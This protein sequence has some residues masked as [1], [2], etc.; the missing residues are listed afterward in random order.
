MIRLAGGV[1]HK[2]WIALSSLSVAALI[3]GSLQSL[4]EPAECQNFIILELPTLSSLASSYKKVVGRAG[5][6]HGCFVF[7]GKL[8]KTGLRFEVSTEWRPLLS[9]SQHCLI[10]KCD[11]ASWF[12]VNFNFAT[13][14]QQLAGCDPW[15]QL[16]TISSC[17]QGFPGWLP[18]TFCGGSR[19]TS[20]PLLPRGCIVLFLGLTLLKESNNLTASSVASACTLSHHCVLTAW[21]EYSLSLSK[22]QTFVLF[23]SFASI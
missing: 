19:R 16:H 2:G 12:L 3:W 1:P 5:E 15:L 7:S 21:R 13:P 6:Q 17:Q 14:V 23:Q 8:T 4:W 20:L 10:S 18:L 22:K 9:G 11:A